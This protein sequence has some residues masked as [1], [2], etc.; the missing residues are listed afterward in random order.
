M[1]IVCA[2]Q[3]RSLPAKLGKADHFI[4]KEAG[5]ITAGSLLSR[6]RCFMGDMSREGVPIVGG[7]EAGVG[8]VRRAQ[9]HA[10][11]PHFVVGQLEGAPDEDKS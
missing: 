11:V 5:F 10:V 2:K 3:E 7:A 9:E 1:S 4:I 8:L 6:V